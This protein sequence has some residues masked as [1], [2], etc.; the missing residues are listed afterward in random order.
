MERKSIHGDRL[1]DRYLIQNRFSGGMGVLWTVTDAR[2]DS[3]Y[4]IKTVLD[5]RFSERFR[6]CARLEAGGFK[7]H[8]IAE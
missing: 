2:T 5:A 4:A 3:P 1:L 8:V 6:H 7:P